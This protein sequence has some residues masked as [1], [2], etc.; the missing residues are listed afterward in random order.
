[1]D[2]SKAV[3]SWDGK[4]KTLDTFRRLCAEGEYAEKPK[5]T[6]EQF[7]YRVLRTVARKHK[8]ELPDDVLASLVKAHGTKKAVLEQLQN[9][10]FELKPTLDRVKKMKASELKQIA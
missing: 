5:E 7:Q 8:G 2:M 9:A 3:S 4:A 6:N 1:M 10:G